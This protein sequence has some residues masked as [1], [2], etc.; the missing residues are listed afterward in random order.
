MFKLKNLWA[1]KS[2]KKVNSNAQEK[3]KGGWAGHFPCPGELPPNA[4]EKAHTNV[5]KEKD[6][7]DD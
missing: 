6:D 5:N 2:I 3:L 1:N 7:E 4:N